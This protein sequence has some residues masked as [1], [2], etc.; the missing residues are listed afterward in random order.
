MARDPPSSVHATTMY[1]LCPM[2]RADCTSKAQSK[3]QPRTPACC[4]VGLV[5]HPFSLPWSQEACALG[6]KVESKQE[7]NPPVRAEPLKMRNVGLNP[8]S[9]VLRPP[10][11]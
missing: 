7:H 3:D 8:P 11:P 6:I 4:H 10:K 9:S 1:V 2:M 5:S